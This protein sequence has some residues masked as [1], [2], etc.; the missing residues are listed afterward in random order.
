MKVTMP[1][2]MVVVVTTLN[3]AAFTSG[4]VSMYT[5]DRWWWIRPHSVVNSQ[6]RATYVDYSLQ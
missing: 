6:C 4:T 3:R 2:I 5:Y 1:K